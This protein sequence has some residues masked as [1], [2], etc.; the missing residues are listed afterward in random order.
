MS[1]IV[2]NIAMCD[3]DPTF[4]CFQLDC[5]IQTLLFEAVG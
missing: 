3:A 4:G 2:E 5:H 1:L